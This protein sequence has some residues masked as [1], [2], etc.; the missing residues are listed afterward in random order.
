MVLI[1][2]EVHP[3]GSVTAEPITVDLVSPAE[4][5]APPKKEEPPRLELPKQEPSDALDLS[6]KSAPPPA[7][8][9]AAPQEAAA[10]PQKQAALTPKQA[11]STHAPPVKQPA[12]A[13]PQP[14]ATSPV[15]GFV[16]PQPDLTIKYNVL[17]GLPPELPPTVPQDKPG[18]GFDAP[19][20][21]TAD[22]A[23]SMI[24]EFRRHLKACSKLPAS[25]APTDPI[26]VKLRVLMAPDGKL[27]ADPILIEASASAK[28]PA[29]MQNAIAALEACQP[30][31]MLP[32]DR[33]GEWKVLDLSFTPQDFTGG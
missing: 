16:P 2:T 1:F 30:Y 27:A 5:T 32:A 18:D 6:S 33:Y 22:I 17:L 26:R 9:S 21:Q 12:A 10:P 31:A 3:F 7:P 13:Q 28:G 25:I 14:P 20:S 23:S 24:A 4:V 15:P 8:A 11:A 19:A 29:L